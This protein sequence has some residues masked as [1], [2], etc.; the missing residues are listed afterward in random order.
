MAP[1]H[2]ANGENSYPVPRIGCDLAE[3]NAVAE[4]IT[5]FG[6]RYLTRVYSEAERLQTA[7]SPQRLAARF[8]GKEAVLKV[9]R[10][11]GGIGYTHIEILNDEVGAPR[12]R[13]TEQALR[14]AREQQLGP[15]AI[16]LS[17]EGGLALATAVA[18]PHN[19][20]QQ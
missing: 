10:N 5:T 1:T 8:A 11:T 3:V 12:V 18:L 13:L 2:T 20:S 7:E 16:S 9:L 17:H 15:I 14:S 4:S 19:R 6:E